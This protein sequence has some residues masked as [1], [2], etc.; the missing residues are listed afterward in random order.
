MAGVI[1]WVGWRHEHWGREIHWEPTGKHTWQPILPLWARAEKV[2]SGLDSFMQRK[3]NMSG[4]IDT[5][6]FQ[7]SSCFKYS[8]I[9]D[10]FG[11][12]CDDDHV[13]SQGLI[14]LYTW[15]LRDS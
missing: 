4:T 11:G 9:L 6:T 13:R 10:L 8:T 14:R 1:Y 7:Q 12:V 5:C 15:G 2:H 3:S